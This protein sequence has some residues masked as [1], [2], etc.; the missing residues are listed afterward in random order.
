MVYVRE[1]DGMTSPTNALRY[2]MLGTVATA[3][4]L[5]PQ[6]SKAHDGAPLHG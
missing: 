6:A 3:G 4:A 2:F 1:E 5:L